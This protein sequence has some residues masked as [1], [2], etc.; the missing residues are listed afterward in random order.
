MKSAHLGWGAAS[1]NRRAQTG[2]VAMSLSLLRGNKTSNTCYSHH[3]AFCDSQ[4]ECLKWQPVRNQPR[5]RLRVSIRERQP[6]P[7][8]RSQNKML[9]TAKHRKAGSFQVVLLFTEY[10]LSLLST[11]CCRSFL[12]VF[13][14]LYYNPLT[15]AG[16]FNSFRPS[17]AN[18]RVEPS[19]GS[20]SPF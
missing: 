19:P 7:A 9:A 6:T 14:V 12:S 5:P 8:I 2:R 13:L 3:F 16:Q 11:P 4:E 10:P 17:S 20:L 1:R 18:T 15:A